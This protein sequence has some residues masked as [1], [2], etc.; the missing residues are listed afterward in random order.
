MWNSHRYRADA[1]ELARFSLTA[2]QASSPRSFSL[3][4]M[5]LSIWRALVNAEP[6]RRRERRHKQARHRSC[7]SSL[8]SRRS[9]A[10][11]KAGASRV[12]AS[13]TMSVSISKYPCTRTLR[14]PMIF[15][16]GMSGVSPRTSSGRA[17][18]ASPIICRWWRNQVCR[19][20]S[21]SK[22]VRSRS[23][24][25]SMAAIASKMSRNRSLGSLIQVQ[26]PVAHARGCVS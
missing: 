6:R 10:N 20:S 13:H 4:Q 1:Q 5:A 14:I 11:F 21:R 8:A 7:A 18:A 16:Q 25:R 17:L 3:F 19:S 22:T 26:P 23:R 12:A 24:Y 2:P 9:T 15:V